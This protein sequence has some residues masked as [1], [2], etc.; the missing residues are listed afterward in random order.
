MSL[1]SQAAGRAQPE[2]PAFPSA[3]QQWMRLL[4]ALL[5]TICGLLTFAYAG[6]TTYMATLLVQQ[7][8]LALAGTPA[9]Y[10]LDYRN[11]EFPA[12]ADHVAIRGW[13][14]P[15]VLPSRQLTSARVLIMVHG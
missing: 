13:F 2:M 4:V 7:H 8:P 15:G 5:L 9:D 1:Q 3:R 12:R 6:I 11:V 14:I 10:R